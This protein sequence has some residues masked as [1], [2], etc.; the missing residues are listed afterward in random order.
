MKL[1]TNSLELAARGCHLAIADIREETLTAVAAELAQFPIRV[2]THVLDVASRER[3]R[4]LADVADEA[5]ERV[6]ALGLA[7]LVVI[8]TF[9]PESTM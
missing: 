2:S 8:A 1:D 3:E 9:A 5:L 7:Q 6:A 4:L